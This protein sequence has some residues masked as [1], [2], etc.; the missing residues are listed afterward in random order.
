MPRR[1]ANMAKLGD[2]IVIALL[3]EDDAD[4]GLVELAP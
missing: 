3:V 2:Q 1:R 4:I